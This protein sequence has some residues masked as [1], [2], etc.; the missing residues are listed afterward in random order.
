MIL[1]CFME[2][3]YIKQHIPKLK[4]SFLASA[5]ASLHKVPDIRNKI[6]RWLVLDVVNVIFKNKNMVL[7]VVLNP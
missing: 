2:K 4:I 5:S 1:K 6:N 7:L 3:K